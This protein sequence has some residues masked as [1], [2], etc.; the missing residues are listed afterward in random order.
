MRLYYAETISPR[1]V[2]AVARYVDAPVE[3]VRLDLRDRETRTPEFLALNPNGKVP[4]LQDGEHCLWESNAIMCRLSELTGADLWPRDKRQIEVLRWLFWDAEH[5]SRHAGRLYFEHIIRPSILDQLNPDVRAVAE[6]LSYFRTYAAILDRHLGGR[7]Y[8]VGD[9]L[10]V[11]DFA[12]GV[13]LPYAKPA[14]IPL[15]EFP[16][17]ARWHERLN[18]IPAWREPFPH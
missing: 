3:F 9:A 7:R 10:T 16:A 8:V 17:I 4:L 6:A 11:A 15:E 2:C 13:T 5:F 14:H 12:L 1:K 18:E